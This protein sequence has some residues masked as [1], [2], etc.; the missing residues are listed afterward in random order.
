[1]KISLII[2]LKNEKETIL[3][4]LMSILN[5][6]KIPD[7]LVIVDGGSIDNTVEI[8]R[9]FMKN[10]KITTRLIIKKSS[11]IAEGRNVAIKNAKYDLIAVTDGGVMLA[12]DWLQEITKPFNKVNEFEVVFGSFRV[13]GKSFIGKCYAEFCNYRRM[14]SNFSTTDLSSRSVAF[15]KNVWKKVGKYPEWLTLAG[16]DTLFF[17]KLKEKC[18]WTTSPNA[19]AYWNHTQETLLQIYERTYRNSVGCGEGNILSL[20]YIFLC[21]VYLIGIFI[22]ILGLKFIIL[23]LILASLA[24]I[25]LMIGSF[26]VY[27]RLNFY[28]VFLIMPFILLVR[29]L[30]MIFGYS[31]GF[32]NRV[33]NPKVKI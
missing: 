20:R 30:G 33:Y 12:N 11:N 32:F 18:K 16:E 22:F 31:N 24:I 25:R 27:K 17:I 13:N 8:I 29:D 26:Y 19:I 2:T 15:K 6:S 14:K 10:T 5:Q 9:G 4:L 7:E 21:C 23:F 28:K 1:M 3:E